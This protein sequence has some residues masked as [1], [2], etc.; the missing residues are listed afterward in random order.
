MDSLQMSLKR[1]QNW[2]LQLAYNSEFITQKNPTY[3]TAMLGY[4]SKWFENLLGTYSYCLP[5]I[6]PEWFQKS[7]GRCYKTV[8][9]MVEIS[10]A[11]T[12]HRSQFFMGI[13]C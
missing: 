9:G 6:I 8:K 4:S 2:P 11:H 10:S 13:T 7:A 5:F 1:C 3:T 12:C